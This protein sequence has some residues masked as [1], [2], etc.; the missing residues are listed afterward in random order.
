MAPSEAL[1]RT[2]L[3]SLLLGAMVYEPDGPIPLDFNLGD[4][5]IEMRRL[6]QNREA[7]GGYES[8]ESGWASILR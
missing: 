6:D 7:S 4:V 2:Y 1:A 5:A 8:L 3:E